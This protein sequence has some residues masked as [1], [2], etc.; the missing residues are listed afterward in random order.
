[1]ISIVIPT[2]NH[3]SSLPASIDAVLSQEGVDLEIIIVND[4]SLD[5]TREVLE[6]Y[7]D[8]VT[9]IHQENAGSNP[10]RNRGAL[11]A[12]GEYVMFLDA[13]ARIEPGALKRLLEV[14][15]GNA[16]AAYAYGDF[17]F[18]FKYLKTGAF[19]ESRL[20]QMNFIH[21]SA[22]IKRAAFPG[23][24]NAI[25][26]FQDWDLWLTMLEQG[27]TGIYVPMLAMKVSVERAGISS[28]L[29]RAWYHAPI[30]WLPGVRQR[31]A[32]YEAA[33][34]IIRKKHRL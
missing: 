26:R 29:P 20:R 7:R 10:A 13:D 14:L 34:E 6:P 27:H 22:L 18:G 33:R 25:K 30:K 8:R 23:F 9:A 24:D 28:W 4:G 19:D 12:T 17:K 21:T 1:M 32:R 16:D 2:Y 3:A 5:N 31:V 15:E 11:E